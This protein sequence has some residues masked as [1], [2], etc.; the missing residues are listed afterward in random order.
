MA[1][2]V[3]EFL[4]SLLFLYMIMFDHCLLISLPLVL[5]T[6]FTR[7]DLQPF[8]R[9]ASEHFIFI[10][11]SIQGGLSTQVAQRE[12]QLARTI[13]AFQNKK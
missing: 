12:S 11:G 3:G 6:I 9:F 4:V 8:I 13:L 5:I 7:K 10:A 2:V 1:Q